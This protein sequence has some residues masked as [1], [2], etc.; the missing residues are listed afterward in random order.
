MKSKSEE[1]VATTRTYENDSTSTAETKFLKIANLTTFVNGG[2][3]SEILGNYG[4]VVRAEIAFDRTEN[5]P[6]GFAFAEMGSA[7]DASNAIAHMDGGMID[8]GEVTLT[9]AS[10]KSMPPPRVAN[11]GVDRG[12]RGGGRGGR[13]FGVRVVARRDSSRD[14]GGN[15]GGHGARGGGGG[16]HHSSPMICVDTSATVPAGR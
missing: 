12:G 8:G 11:D 1:G 9:F 15:G 3:L 4:V 6:T 7:R 13:G 14:R 10:E 2:H 5:K 16:L